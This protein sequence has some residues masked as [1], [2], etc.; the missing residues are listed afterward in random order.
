MVAMGDADASVRQQAAHVTGKFAHRNRRFALRKNVRGAVV[1]LTSGLRHR[2][3]ARRA[4]EQARSEFLLDPADSLRYRG[5]RQPKLVRSTDKGARLD[6]L[7]KDR[8]ALEIGELRH[9]KFHRYE[10]KMVLYLCP[11]RVEVIASTGKAFEI[12]L[13]QAV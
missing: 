8:Q 3:T 2:E 12:E 5:F 4:I 13:V 11:D 1:K 10:P 7:R 9:V 6:D